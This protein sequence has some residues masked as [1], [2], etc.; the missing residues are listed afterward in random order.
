MQPWSSV[1]HATLK[2]IHVE[3]MRDLIYVT[4]RVQCA[5]SL[6]KHAMLG[7]TSQFHTGKLTLL[8]PRRT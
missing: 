2:A 8:A 1:L 4:A 3:Q 7:C 5:V 6:L